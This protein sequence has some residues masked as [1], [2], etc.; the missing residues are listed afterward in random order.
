ME[1]VT[2]SYHTGYSV[3]L[4]ADVTPVPW[5]ETNI[6]GDYGKDFMRTK[7][8]NQSFNDLHCTASVAVFPI[9]T[10]EIRS[11]CNFMHDMIEP[12]KYKDASMLS[13]SVQYKAKWAVWKLTGENLLNVR[14][15]TRTSFMDTDRF[16]HTTN[17]VGRTVMLTCKL[18]LAGEK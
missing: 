2:I 7:S 6:K 9:P 14:Q 13:A 15:Y 11:T 10:I 8:S 5:L 4:Q 1:G 12:G 18:L 17:L 16:V 3:R